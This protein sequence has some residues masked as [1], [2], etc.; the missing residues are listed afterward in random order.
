MWRCETRADRT[1]V[2]PL[3]AAVRSNTVMSNPNPPPD[4]GGGQQLTPSYHTTRRPRDAS[5]TFHG[6]ADANEP[7][8]PVLDGP[9]RTTALR[10]L[11]S[12]FVALCQT[13]AYAHSR[14]VLHRDLKPHNVML[15]PFG[16]TLLVDWGLALE[17]R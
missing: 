12:R 2:L 14:G 15:G 6:I 4:T 9:E 17:L 13:V 16:E 1:A 11:L 5:R 8:P 10:R 7:R 3:R